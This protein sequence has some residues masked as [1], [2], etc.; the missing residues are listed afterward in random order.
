VDIE[1]NRHQHEQE[2]LMDRE[3]HEKTIKER[4]EVNNDDDENCID[5]FDQN[6]QN[7]ENN[8]NDQNDEKKGQ[9]TVSF[10]TPLPTIQQTPEETTPLPTQP[11]SPAISTISTTSA[12]QLPIA[13]NHPTRQL[14]PLFNS[15]WARFF[16]HFYG[17]MSHYNNNGQIY[18]DDSNIQN[19]VN[20]IDGVIFTPIPAGIV[21]NAHYTKLTQNAQMDDVLSPQ[22]LQKY[23]KI[24]NFGENLPQNNDGLLCLKKLSLPVKPIDTIILSKLFDTI[25][26]SVETKMPQSIEY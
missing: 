25:I 9:K 1:N 26:R 10:S 8:E 11:L 14:V 23:K 22:T 21:L 18:D 20:V 6:D 17:F 24:S 12:T 5:N 13:I 3:E 4:R 2:V 7:N 19:R 15:R 16:E